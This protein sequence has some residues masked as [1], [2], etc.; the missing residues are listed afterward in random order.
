MQRGGQGKGSKYKMP[1]LAFNKMYIEV[2]LKIDF[3]QRAGLFKHPDCFIIGRREDVLAVVYGLVNV[4]GVDR[5][6]SSAQFP[7]LFQ[8]NWPESMLNGM[9][10]RGYPRQPSANDDYFFIHSQ[11]PS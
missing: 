3:M 7:V 5:A 2:F 4:I 6:N 11:I 1:P 9:D 8:N 10:C